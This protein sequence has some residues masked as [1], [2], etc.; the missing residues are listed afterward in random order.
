[1]KKMIACGFLLLI[2]SSIFVV[3]TYSKEA[4]LD[5]FILESKVLSSHDLAKKLVRFHVIANSDAEVDQQVKLKVKDDILEYMVPKLEVSTSKDETI[6]II[7]ENSEEIQHIAQETLHTYNMDNEVSVELE[8][9]FFP[10]K[11]Y[12][13]FSLPA[14]DYLALRVIIGNGQGKNWWCVLFPPLC[15]VDVKT[16]VSKEEYRNIPEEVAFKEEDDEDE[17]KYQTED[18]T[19][20]KEPSNQNKLWEQRED[21]E[22]HL[23]SDLETTIDEEDSLEK[24]KQIQC[25]YGKENNEEKRQEEKASSP[26]RSFEV[27]SSTSSTPKIRWKALELLGFYN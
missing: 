25:K 13:N 24:E 2:L 18:T 26:K 5:F 6:K 12:K 19:D 7:D 16:E 14:G 15:L 20:S 10:T 27:S 11:Y 23:E 1:M 9:T 8:T 21:K 22:D 17:E 3:N 4:N